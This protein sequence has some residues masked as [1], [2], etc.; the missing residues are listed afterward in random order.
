MT[1]SLLKKTLMFAMAIAFAI[2]QSADAHFVWIAKDPKTGEM[3]VYFG[4]GPEPDQK[5]FL[6]GISKIKLSECVN[7]EFAKTDFTEKSDGDNGWFVCN[8]KHQPSEVV[9]DVAYGVF[10]RGDST[11]FL[12]YSAKYG[13]LNGTVSLSSKSAS[14]LPLDIVAK[15]TDKKIELTAEYRGKVLSNSEFAIVDPSG[16]SIEKSTDEK[17]SLSLPAMPGRYLIRAKHV[18]PS[19]GEHDGKRFSE[20]R[21]YCTLVLDNGETSATQVP[22]SNNKTNGVQRISIANIPEGVTS[23][24]GA[25]T[26]NKIYIYGGHTGKP[27]SYY[28]SGQNDKLYSIDLSNPSKWKVA[29]KGLGLQGL[30]MVA[31]QGKLYRLGGFHAHNQEGEKHDLRSV[32]EFAVYD[33]TKR[34]W[35]QLEP[36]PNGRS[37]F[38]SVIVNGVIYVIGGWE[39]NGK[40]GTRWC[41]TALSFDLNVK[42][43]NWQKLPAPPFKR[44]ALSVGFQNN[45]LI[46]I[47]GMQEKGGPTKKVAIYDLLSKAW[48][49]GPELPGDGRMEGFGSSCFNV[50]GE[51]IVSTYG[52][53]LL[54]LN[55]D[56][57]QWQVVS[58]CDEGRFFHRLL[59]LNQNDF[60]LVGGASMESGKFYEVEVY[61]K[62]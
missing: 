9:G 11:M 24:G 46:V 27:H 7:G 42:D 44:R 3:K 38:D 30:A 6:K 31:H 58:T 20:T 1:K 14:I 43:S 40:N 39:M 10:S 26:D 4:E 21:Y 51:L 48:S 25:V 5:M 33:S 37:S 35:N 52:G 49:D 41:D 16:A 23:F 18:D 47:G 53:N 59:P 8:S 22:S 45:K 50:G 28:Q 60:V 36:M 13:A 56:L 55:S 15:R 29:G 12:H 32:K 54:K 57:S 19:A 17:G 2:P 34:S 62:Q 61:S